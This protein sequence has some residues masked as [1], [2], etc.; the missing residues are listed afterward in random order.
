MKLLDGFEIQP[1]RI[2][3]NG[4]RCAKS[5]AKLA[6]VALPTFLA[7]PPPLMVV[8]VRTSS[9]PEAAWPTYMMLACVY[10]CAAG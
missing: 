3:S 6:V 10:D 2:E 5:L 7:L 8:F 9:S 4:I 1:A